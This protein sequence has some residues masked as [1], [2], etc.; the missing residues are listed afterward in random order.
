MDDPMRDC[1][2]GE[3]SVMSTTACIASSVTQDKAP[4]IGYCA[5]KRFFSSGLT[6]TRVTYFLGVG[7]GG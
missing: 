2:S 5:R 7:I 1:K 6:N 4:G 3:P